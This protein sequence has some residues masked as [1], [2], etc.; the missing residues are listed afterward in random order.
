MEHFY[1]Y[2]LHNSWVEYFP[3]R[4]SQNSKVSF[5]VCSVRWK[6]NNPVGKVDKRYLCWSTFCSQVSVGTGS[7]L[8]DCME[9][10]ENWGK[11]RTNSPTAQIKRAEKQKKKT[12]K[13][14]MKRY[15]EQEEVWLWFVSK[16]QQ[17][18]LNQVTA[19]NT[20]ESVFQLENWKFFFLLS[21]LTGSHIII[22]Y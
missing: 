18:I 16:L 5:S 22:S 6:A 1:A 12:W 10:R 21:E 14:L 11:R 9:K 17:H 2:K 4:V 8:H 19:R 15:V 7:H 3:P 13:H 20:L